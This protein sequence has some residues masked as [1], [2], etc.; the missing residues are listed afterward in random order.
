MNLQAMGRDGAVAIDARSARWHW[1]HGIGTYT[2]ELVSA[3]PPRHLGYAVRC[4]GLDGAQGFPAGTGAAGIYE[5]AGAPPP[6]NRFWQMASQPPELLGD[7]VLWHNPHSGIGLP[8]DEGLPLV[9]TVHDL[10]PLVMPGAAGAGFRGLFEEQ[11]PAAA[12]RAARIITPSEHSKADLVQLLGVDSGKITVIGEA[13]PC[14]LRPVP[15]KEAL[16]RVA[17]RYRLTSPYVLYVGG[18]SPRKNVP[19]L[20][21]AFALAR[22][23]LPRGQALA[24]AGSPE[25]G[26][27]QLLELAHRLGCASAVTCLGY[28]AAADLPHLYSGADVF[29]YPSLY[30]GFGL[31]PLEAMACGCPVVCSDATSLPEVCGTAAELVDSRDPGAMAEAIARVVSDPFL[32]EFMRA[33]G[34]AHA[35]Q[36]TWALV[37]KR[38]L[39]VY[40]EPLAAGSDMRRD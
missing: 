35:A 23:R 31:P 10:I 2:A 30:E 12:T 19:A 13:P 17:S 8:L 9:V 39:A 15:R 38:T 36:F 24:I 1:G 7:E 33:R 26:H 37:A 16:A 11:V 4:W 22:P 29:V 6:G 27:G 25:Q 20:I 21:A 40:T 5:G 32:A 3:L 34:L 18:L 14:S 28:V